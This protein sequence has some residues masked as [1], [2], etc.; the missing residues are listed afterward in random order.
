[1]SNYFVIYL[2]IKVLVEGNDFEPIFRKNVTNFNRYSTSLD[3]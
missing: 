2:S 3:R 1:M